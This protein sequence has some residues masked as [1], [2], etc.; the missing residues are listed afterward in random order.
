MK[1]ILGVFL[2]FGQ[3]ERLMFV[4]LLRR[5]GRSLYSIFKLRFQLVHD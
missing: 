4:D 1:S 2:C 3:I 5:H